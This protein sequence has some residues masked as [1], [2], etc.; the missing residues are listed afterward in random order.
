MP[1][2]LQE[3]KLHKGPDSKLVFASSIRP[4]IAYHSDWVW[5]EALKQA[6]IKNFRFHDLRHTCASYLAQN[7]ATLLEIGDVLG[8]R[9]LSVTKRY[10]HLATGQKSALINRVLGEIQ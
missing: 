7:G 3:L 6:R 10:S 4:D 1:A 8:H 2:V 9:N 5:R